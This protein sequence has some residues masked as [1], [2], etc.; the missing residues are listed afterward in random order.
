MSQQCAQV[1][2][3]ASGI[4]AYISN[5]VASRSREVILPLY[6]VLVRPHLQYCVQF[7]K[8]IE[9]LE[10]VQRRAMKLLMCLECMSL[11]EQLRELGL[12]SLE[13]RRLKGDFIALDTCLKGG[14]SQVGVSFF[15]QATNNRKRGHSL[16][17]HQG[18][19]RFDIRKNFFTE[20]VIGYWN[21]LP[22]VV[23]SPSLGVFKERL[24]MANGLDWILSAMASL[25]WWF[26]IIGWIR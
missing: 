15:S 17:L 6:L 1:A 24:D 10:C 7:R 19:F 16:K 18:R 14:C 21:G 5:S 2:K 26:S 8:A 13:R 3:K 25:T 4:L 22:R 9:V 12:F 20:R 23:E 11:E